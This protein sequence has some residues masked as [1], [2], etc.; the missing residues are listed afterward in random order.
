[1]QPDDAAKKGAVLGGVAGGGIGAWIV[2]GAGYTTVAIV[3][4]V[5]GGGIVGAVIVGVAAYGVAKALDK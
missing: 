2:W 4:I 1:M 3:G 5:G